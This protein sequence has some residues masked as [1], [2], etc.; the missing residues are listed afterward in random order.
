MGKSWPAQ[1][2]GC[3]CVGD[4]SKRKTEARQSARRTAS[5][6]SVIMIA[7]SNAAWLGDLRRAIGGPNSVGAVYPALIGLDTESD[8][9][10][11]IS[12]RTCSRR[13]AATLRGKLFAGAFVMDGEKNRGTNVLLH[14]SQSGRKTAPLSC[15]S[16]GRG[17]PIANTWHHR[18]TLGRAYGNVVAG[19]QVPNR[20]TTMS[21][22]WRVFC[23]VHKCSVEE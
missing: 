15:I 18:F 23:L 17:G 7:A 1:T 20:S 22:N 4:R 11:V 16:P 3:H 13:H 2:V 14:R 6:S 10:M 5:T 21:F 19:S 9:A 12:L 8:A